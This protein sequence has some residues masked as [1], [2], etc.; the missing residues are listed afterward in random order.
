MLRRVTL[1]T[2]A[3]LQH[4]APAMLRAA[5]VAA[6][7][8]GTRI[9]LVRMLAKPSSKIDSFQTVSVCCNKCRAKLF[10]YKKKN[11]LKSNLV[12]CYIERI[13]A[14]P[15]GIL[16]GR[17]SAHE[18]EWRCP[19]C[20]SAFARSAQIHGRPALKMVGGKVRMTK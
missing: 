15:F 12:K 2:L 13:V 20:D 9:T 8:P 1:C 4:A 5:P 16:D 3:L 19:E 6:P 10:R 14:D 17:D 11:G 18:G 7:S